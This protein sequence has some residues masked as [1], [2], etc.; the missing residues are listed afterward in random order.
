MFAIRNDAASA[1]LLALLLIWA[2]SL[3][4]SIG[5]SWPSPEKRLPLATGLRMASSATLAL[6]A[7]SWYLVARDIPHVALFAFL[8]AIGMSLG[9]LGDLL[10]ANF[11]P[12]KQ[13]F[14]AGMAAFALGHFAYIA[15]ILTLTPRIQWAAEGIALLAGLAGW[16]LAVFRAGQDNELLRWAALP[17]ALL[18]ATTVGAASGLALQAPQFVP[19]AIG[20]ALFPISDLLVA[21]QQFGQLRFLHIGDAIWL[22]YG[23]AQVLIVYAVNSALVVAATR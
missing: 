14:L 19:L 3:L 17:Y 20:A 1:W 5:A 2:L 11:L 13:G 16:Y 22:T 18:L 15:A 9:L 8:I 7:W 23:P 10:L 21:G 6:A 12:L 4:G